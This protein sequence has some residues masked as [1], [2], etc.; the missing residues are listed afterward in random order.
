MAGQQ[1]GLEVLPLRMSSSAVFAW[2]RLQGAQ[3][4]L[5]RHASTPSFIATAAMT[6]PAAG[7]AQDQ[8]DV[9]LTTSPS[10]STADR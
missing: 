2:A 4:L 8:P 5:P 6:R 10:S 9:A 3:Q 1:H 7:W